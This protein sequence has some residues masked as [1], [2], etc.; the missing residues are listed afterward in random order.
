MAKPELLDQKSSATLGPMTG[1]RSHVSNVVM[2]SF[3]LVSARFGAINIVG[4]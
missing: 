2:L 1:E 4:F 3:V